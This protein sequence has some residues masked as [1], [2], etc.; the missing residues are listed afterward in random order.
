M[1]IQTVA[2]GTD[3]L[4]TTSL[5]IGCAS[6]FRASSSEERAQLLQTAYDAGIR[7]FDVA[8]MYGFG[9]GESELGTFARGR[10]PELTIVTKSGYARPARPAAWLAYRALAPSSREQSRPP[11]QVRT[12]AAGPTKGRVGRLL[13]PEEGY[14]AS[15]PIESGAQPLGAQDSPPGYAASAPSASGQR[16][17]SATVPFVFVRNLRGLWWPHTLMQ[18]IPRIDS[19]SV[20]EYIR[21]SENRSGRPTSTGISAFIRRPLY[22]CT[23]GSLGGVP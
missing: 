3:Q 1:S 22:G 21:P 14:D 11:Y 20:R 10:R 5:G 18:V 16:P 6:L 13:Y 15:G 9:L 8:P 7:Y 4:R 12:R 23:V 2:L 19:G 17:L